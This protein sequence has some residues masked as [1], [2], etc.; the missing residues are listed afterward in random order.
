MKKTGKTQSRQQAKP[1][2][3]SKRKATQK[4]QEYPC[5]IEACKDLLRM[6]LV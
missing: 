3:T 6:E 2:E 4:A 1:F 5:C